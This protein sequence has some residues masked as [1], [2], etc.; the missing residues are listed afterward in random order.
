MPIN[1]RS[2]SRLKHAESSNN[3]NVPKSRTHSRSLSVPDNKT[4]SEFPDITSNTHRSQDNLTDLS[5]LDQAPFKGFSHLTSFTNNSVP[6]S[7]DMASNENSQDNIQPSGSGIARNDLDLLGKIQ[8]AVR[9]S[10]DEFRNELSAL[11]ETL[12]NLTVNPGS[13]S[14]SPGLSLNMHN[15]SSSVFPTGSISNNPNL[16]KWKITFD[17]TGNVQDF[18]FQNRYIIN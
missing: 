8:E 2:S 12:A 5:V 16:E 3:L 7:L 15:T 14:Q 4:S 18:S 6:S 11:R 13:I 1:T 17:G 9:S 10:Q